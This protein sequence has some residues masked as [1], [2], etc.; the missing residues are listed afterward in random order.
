MIDL[1]TPV[2]ETELA[3]LLWRSKITTSAHDIVRRLAYELGV[4]KAHREQNVA[5]LKAENE[6]LRSR[7]RQHEPAIGD[8]SWLDLINESG[9]GE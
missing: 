3:E 2:S 6:W 7:L 1:S 8:K 4:L 5:D 9:E